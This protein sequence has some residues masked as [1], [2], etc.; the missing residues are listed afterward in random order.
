MRIVW[1]RRALEELRAIADQVN[2]QSPAAAI[3]LRDR[4]RS[5]VTR[6]ADFPAS[7]RPGRVAETREL[8]I[9][10]SRY[11][12]PYRIQDGQV[13]ILAIFHAARDWPEEL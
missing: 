11:I 2:L 12:A 3:M 4:I 9:P 1:T 5:A 10:G 13:E 6:L 7:G 8:V